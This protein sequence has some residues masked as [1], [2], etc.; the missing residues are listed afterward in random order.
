MSFVTMEFYGES[1]QKMCSLYVLTPDLEGPLPVL[2][3]L[4]GLSDNHSVWFRRTALERVAFVIHEIFRRASEIKMAEGR[5]LRIPIT[6]QHLGD[7]L[8]LSLVHTNKTL[9]Q[10]VDRK[11]LKWKA[12]SMEVLDIAKLADIAEIEAVAPALRPLI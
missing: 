2:Y 5:Q 8:G 9:K 11:I 10:L 12:G 4:H 6:Q 7:A 3:L 1:I